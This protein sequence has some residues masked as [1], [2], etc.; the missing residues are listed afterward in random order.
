MH[1]FGADSA[2]AQRIAHSNG[3][4]CAKRKVVRAASPLI[5]V[6]LKAQVEVACLVLDNLAGSPQHIDHIRANV[7]LVNIESNVLQFVLEI[8]NSLLEC[9]KLRLVCRALNG[10]CRLCGVGASAFGD[11]APSR[12]QRHC[13]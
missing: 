1:L 13:D 11:L 7:K 5:G 12:K 3:T 6:A 10:L 4:F 8:G 2:S 9:V